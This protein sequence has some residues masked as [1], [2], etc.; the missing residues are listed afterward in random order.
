MSGQMVV[1]SP[2]DLEPGQ[3]VRIVDG[4]FSG[5]VGTVYKVYT[6]EVKVRVMIDL[7]G[8]KTPIELDFFQVAKT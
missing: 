5:F 1:N 8:R 2:D 4:P 3:Q 6:E 7:L